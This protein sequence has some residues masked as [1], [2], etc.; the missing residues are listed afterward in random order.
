MTIVDEGIVNEEGC[1]EPLAVL[2]KY[3]V[4]R[5][6]YEIYQCKHNMA[7]FN[8]KFAITNL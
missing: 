3:E 4:R 6:K 5:M 7:L 2:Q 1:R 8:L